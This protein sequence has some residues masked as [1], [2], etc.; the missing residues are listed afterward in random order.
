MFESD[1][2]VWKFLMNYIA[3]IENLLFPADKQPN[4]KPVKL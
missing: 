3:D 4:V 1:I 2:H